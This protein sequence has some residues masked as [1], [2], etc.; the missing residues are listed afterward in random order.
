M[1]NKIGGWT[2]FQ[3]FMDD[4]CTKVNADPDLSGH[5]RWWRHMT[6]QTFVTDGKVKGQRVVAPGDP[7]N[8]IMVHALLGDTPDFSPT[9]RFKRMPLGGPFFDD[10]DI[11]EIEDWIQRGCP[12]TTDPV[13]KPG[14]VAKAGD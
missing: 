1:A 2:D 9:G 12:E 14:P 11:L 8:S 5:G 3:Q 6:Y 4:C 10:A 13:V 7:A